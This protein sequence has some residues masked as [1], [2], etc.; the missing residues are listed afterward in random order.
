MWV[1]DQTHPQR[2][3]SAR[4]AAHRYGYRHGSPILVLHL[5]LS[6]GSRFRGRRPLPGARNRVVFRRRVGVESWVRNHRTGA[7]KTLTN[8]GGG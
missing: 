6:S 5:P 7:G 8:A 4:I 2:R 3:R 1:Q